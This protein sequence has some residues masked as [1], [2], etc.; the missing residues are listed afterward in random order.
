MSKKETIASTYK[1]QRL[2]FYI[3]KKKKTTHII[4]AYIKFNL[5]IICTTLARLV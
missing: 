1:K 3:Y 5:K 4:N 2:F